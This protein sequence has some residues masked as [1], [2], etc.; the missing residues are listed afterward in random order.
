MKRIAYDVTL[1]R[2]G[3]VLLQAA[4]RC[5]PSVVHAFDSETW[6]VFP[7]P[8][9]RVYAATDEEL[10]RLVEITHRNA[11]GRAKRSA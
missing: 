11:K 1:K 2:P 6:L 9:L 10:S 7:T 4:L 3:C 8:D 5:D